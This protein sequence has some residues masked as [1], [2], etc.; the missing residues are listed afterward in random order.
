MSC[1]DKSPIV[2]KGRRATQCVAAS[3]FHKHNRSA[4][5]L[6]VKGTEGLF[7]NVEMK[8]LRVTKFRRAC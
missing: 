4:L 1:D 3:R 8:F 5:K 7:G 6:V 2:K